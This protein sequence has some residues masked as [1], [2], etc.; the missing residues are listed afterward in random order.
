MLSA[1]LQSYIN[2]PPSRTFVEDLKNLMRRPG[3]IDD[4]PNILGKDN[5]PGFVEHRHDQSILT[6]VT[7]RHGIL[8]LLEPTQYGSQ[9]NAQHQLLD[10]HRIRKSR[11]GLRYQF[12]LWKRRRR[13]S[14]LGLKSI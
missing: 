5:L 14:R 11:T 2:C 7:K 6:L 13:M 4:R 12:W 8:P 1:G 9:K 3:L 10:L